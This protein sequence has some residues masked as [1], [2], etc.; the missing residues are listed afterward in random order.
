MI[1]VL[2]IILVIPFIL[3]IY[4]YIYIDIDK[5]FDKVVHT[6]L[7]FKL[8]SYGIDGISNVQND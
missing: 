8:Q 7:Q 6:T 1:G 4:I 5:A 2:H 3:Y